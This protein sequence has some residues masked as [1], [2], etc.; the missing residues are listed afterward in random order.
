MLHQIFSGIT[1]FAQRITGT[2]QTAQ[3]E[4]AKDVTG[5]MGYFMPDP[6]DDPLKNMC[7]AK[8]GPAHMKQQ[9]K[10]EEILR[11]VK[12]TENFMKQYEKDGT[13]DAKTATTMQTDLKK[14]AIKSVQNSDPTTKNIL[15]REFE[16]YE[17]S[18]NVSYKNSPLLQEI[19]TLLDTTP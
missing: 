10:L 8:T 15:R 11:Q 4:P 6:R 1:S 16:Q 18:G 5:G 2:N 9:M 7:Q 3:D 12:D 19:K 13:I 17:E 14:E